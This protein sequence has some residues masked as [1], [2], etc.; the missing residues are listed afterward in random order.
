MI[1]IDVIKLLLLWLG[2]PISG[3]LICLLLGYLTTLNKE[4]K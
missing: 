4:D 3:A 1:D 2:M